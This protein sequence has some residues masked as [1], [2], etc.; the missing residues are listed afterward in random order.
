M[1]TLPNR[2]PYSQFLGFASAGFA[3]LAIAMIVLGDPLWLGLPCSVAAVFLGGWGC[4]LDEQSVWSLIGF[5][6]GL[7]AA[8]LWVV[9]VLVIQRWFGVDSWIF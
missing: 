8:M 3:S 7:L 9:I 4:Q 5:N 1:A 2:S 6:V